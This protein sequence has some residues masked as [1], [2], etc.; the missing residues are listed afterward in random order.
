MTWPT[1]WSQKQATTLWSAEWRIIIRTRTRSRMRTEQSTMDVHE[2][3]SAETET[4][5]RPRRYKL[6]RRCRDVWWKAT[7]KIP[8]SSLQMALKFLEEFLTSQSVHSYRRTL[9]TSSNGLMICKCH[10]MLRSVKLCTLV[11]QICNKILICATANL[12]WLLKKI[13]DLGVG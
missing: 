4:R 11:H 7:L 13:K 10:L 3:F 2:T 6:P 1:L 9:I 12:A 5:L 8:F